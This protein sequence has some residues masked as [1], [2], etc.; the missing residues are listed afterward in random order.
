[1]LQPWLNQFQGSQWKGKA[2]LWLDPN[3]N[4]AN[5][6]ECILAF[7]SR[8]LTYSWAYEGET[9]TGSFIFDDDGATWTDSWH[10]PEPVRCQNLSDAWGLFTVEY[11]Y[12]VPSGPDWGWRSKLS[13]RPDGSLVLQMTNIAPW[14]E[15]GRAVRMIS[16]RTDSDT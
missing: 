5:V 16:Q 3:G 8:V 2:E 7:E 15:E 13:Q 10:Q 4:E 14:G 9:K 12:S 1:M 6:S 11:S